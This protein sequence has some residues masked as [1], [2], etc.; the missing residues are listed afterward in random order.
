MLEKNIETREKGWYRKGTWEEKKLINRQ[1]T[2]L[3]DK[4]MSE[5]GGR[6]RRKN[7]RISERMA[8]EE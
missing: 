3:E 2:K 8:K 4:G 6:R 1:M 5:K 7:E